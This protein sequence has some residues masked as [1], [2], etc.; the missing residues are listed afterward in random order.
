MGKPQIIGLVKAYVPNSKMDK[1]RSN[2]FGKKGKARKGKK[3]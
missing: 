3:K 2:P 1:K